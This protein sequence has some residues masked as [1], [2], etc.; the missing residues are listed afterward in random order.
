MNNTY[1]IL[2]YWATMDDEDLKELNPLFLLYKMGIAQG[3]QVK[4]IPQRC[5]SLKIKGYKKK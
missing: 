1:F 2:K 5:Q 4:R 3:Q